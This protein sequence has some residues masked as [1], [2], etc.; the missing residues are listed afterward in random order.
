MVI[1][2]KS[3]LKSLKLYKEPKFTPINLPLVRRTFPELF[4]NK[5]VSV[6]PMSKPVGLAYAL[7]M[8]DGSKEGEWFEYTMPRQR[9]PTGVYI[10]EIDA[11]EYNFESEEGKWFKYTIDLKGEV[12]E[13]NSSC[14]RKS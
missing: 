14:I 1:T 5:I 6:Q 11:T 3:L 10:K 9:I 8:G 7:K 13:N 2:V 4:A 12:N